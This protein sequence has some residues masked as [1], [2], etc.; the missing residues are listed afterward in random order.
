MSASTVKTSRFS[1]YGKLVSPNSDP[2]NG[3]DISTT[4]DMNRL[5]KISTIVR[6]ITDPYTVSVER[7][8]RLLDIMIKSLTTLDADDQFKDELEA[9]SK[10]F[11]CLKT[12]YTKCM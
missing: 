10:D 11:T 9:F 7:Y 8:I 1:I 2:D 4:N 12:K 6:D 5:R 3:T